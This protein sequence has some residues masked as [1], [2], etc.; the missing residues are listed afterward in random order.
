MPSVVVFFEVHQPYRLN[1][2]MHEKLISRA[3]SG[4]LDLID[5]EEIVFDNELNRRVIERV[6]DKCYLPATRII[7]ENIEKYKSTS[8]PFKVTFSLSGVFLEQAMKWRPDV[9]DLFKKAVDTGFVELAEQTY[10]HSVVAFMPYYGL[11]ELAEQVNEHRRITEE[12][13]G[14][15]PVT[16]ENTEFTY[17]NELACFLYRLGFKVMLTEG[18]DWVLGWRSPNYV[19]RADGCDMRVLTRNYRLSDDVGFRF[20][21]RRWDQYPLT[22]DKYAAWLS[23]TPGDVVFI[24]MDYETF[25]EHHWPETGIY[26]FLRW[27]PGEVLKYGNLEFLST[28]EAAFKYSARDVL[29]VPWWST[30]SWADERDLS[31]WLGNTMQQTAFNLVT[32]LRPY[33]KA[34]EKPELIRLWKLLTISDHY[35]YMATKFGAMGEVHAYFS[36]YKDASVAYGLLMEVAGLLVKLVADEIRANKTRVLSKLVLPQHKAFYFNMPTGE[37]TGYSARSLPEFLEMLEKVPAESFI[38][39]LNRGDFENWLR[40][41]FFL[42]D[43]AEEISR[44]RQQPGS[45]QEKLTGVARVIR[46]ALGV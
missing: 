44:V 5:L 20:S 11:E 14:Y 18:V 12:T 26:E 4:R 9:V 29:S 15:R 21:D 33:V 25:G 1:R 2:R 27:L 40:Q 13:F 45:Y 41:V 30:I 38:Y 28:S 39:H 3:L 16:V 23:A 17:N 32:D 19:Y 22:A 42:E 35:Y 43:E 7:V 8:K 36:P 24:A 34:V 31:A 6:A 46:R 10:Y 37:F